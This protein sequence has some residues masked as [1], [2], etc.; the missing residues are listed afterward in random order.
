[1][2]NVHRSSDVQPEGWLYSSLGREKRTSKTI[3]LKK[4]RLSGEWSFQLLVS[5]GVM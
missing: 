3:S 4:H 5:A 2:L 1:M